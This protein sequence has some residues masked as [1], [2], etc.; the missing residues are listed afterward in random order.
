M[1]LQAGELTE[2][3]LE[4]LGREWQRAKGAPLPTAGVEDRRLLFAA[5]AHGLLAYLNAKQDQVIATIDL[6][7]AGT[8]VRYQVR[9]LDLDISAP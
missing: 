2:A 1:A 4:A 9:A 8:R 7:Q 5:V 3:M 6:E